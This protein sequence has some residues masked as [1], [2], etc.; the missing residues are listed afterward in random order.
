MHLRKNRQARVRFLITH[1]M[2]QNGISYTLSYEYV[3]IIQIKIFFISIVIIS[4][5][6]ELRYAQF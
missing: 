4:L 6:L 5:V 2:I 3:R 1:R